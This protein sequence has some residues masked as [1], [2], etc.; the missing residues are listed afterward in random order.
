MVNLVKYYSLSLNLT[1]FES[2]AWTNKKWTHRKTPALKRPEDP[3]VLKKLVF[4]LTFLSKTLPWLLWAHSSSPPSQVSGLSCRDP[5]APG[6]GLGSDSVT[7]ASGDPGHVTV[8]C[9]VTCACPGN[10]TC[11]GLCGER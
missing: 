10:V 4:N 9:S 5:L 3:Q 6:L 7:A 8:T 11:D 2:R 1:W